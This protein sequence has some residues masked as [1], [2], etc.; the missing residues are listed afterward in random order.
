MEDWK[1]NHR[2]GGEVTQECENCDGKGQYTIATNPSTGED[3]FKKCDECNGCK[4][5]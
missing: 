3:V 4:C 5:R 1:L 2:E